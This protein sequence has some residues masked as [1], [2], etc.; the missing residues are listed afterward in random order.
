MYSQSLVV[1]GMAEA[2]QQAGRYARGRVLGE[3]TW[4]VVHDCV[5]SSD[6]RRV[7][8]KRFKAT[9][10]EEGMNFTAIREIKYLRSLKHDNIIEVSDAMACHVGTSL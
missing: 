3:G 5:R 2:R 10:I 4:G 1:G 6:G 8:V 7:A 9:S